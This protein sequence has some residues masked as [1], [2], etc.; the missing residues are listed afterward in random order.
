MITQTHHKFYRS[1]DLPVKL[2]SYG[3]HI[4]YIRCNV[5]W[6]EE[7]MADL[8]FSAFPMKKNT[9]NTDTPFRINTLIPEIKGRWRSQSALS[10]G[11]PGIPGRMRASRRPRRLRSNT[12][13]A[14]HGGLPATRPELPRPQGAAG[15]SAVSSPETTGR[16]QHLRLRH[17]KQRFGAAAATHALGAKR[18]HSPHPP[19]KTQKY[20]GLIGVCF[21]INSLSLPRPAGNCPFSAI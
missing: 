21:Q 11:M 7:Q 10:S 9:H 5:N 19:E 4:N 15:S 18:P 20:L 6:E 3:R 2:S 13:S 8:P 17:C 12:V 16:Q 14:T 1:T